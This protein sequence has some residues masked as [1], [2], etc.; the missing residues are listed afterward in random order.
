M[1]SLPAVPPKISCIICAYNEAPRIGAVLAVVVDHPLI[2][3]VLV[4][5]DGS[6]DGTAQVVAPFMA[7]PVASSVARSASVRLISCAVNRGKSAAMAT[8]V[9]QASY[10]LLMLLDADLKGLTAANV[11]ALARPVLSGGVEVSISLR[12]NSLAIFRA[13]GLDFVSGERVVHKALLA[14]ALT[15][16]HRLPR[17][18]IEVFMNRRIIARH[19][20]IAVVRW[21]QVSQARKTEKMGYWRGVLAECR[22]V[23]DVLRVIY[24]LA[25][26]SQTYRLRALRR[27]VV[28]IDADADADAR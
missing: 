5:D 1:Q 24:P 3:E 25:A 27:A 17:F 15:E 8:G 21:R 10:P 19:L 9:A 14:E 11:T 4:V 12:R 7:Q 20:S 23:R 26:I 22:M 16:M 28:P 2:A 13:L 6:T 18:G